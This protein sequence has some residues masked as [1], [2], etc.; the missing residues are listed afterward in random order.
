MIGP[1]LG[2]DRPKNGI[3]QQRSKNPID[4]IDYPLPVGTPGDGFYNATEPLLAH[5]D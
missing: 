4:P 3:H 5:P 2:P 1:D